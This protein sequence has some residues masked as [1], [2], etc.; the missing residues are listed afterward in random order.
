MTTYPAIRQTIHDTALALLALLAHTTTGN[1][2]RRVVL[3]LVLFVFGTFTT[4]TR[5]LLFLRPSVSIVCNTLYCRC[6]IGAYAIVGGWW[7][8]HQ[9]FGSR[10]NID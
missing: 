9:W 6:I 2:R 8:I 10:I 3:L 5:S 1:D 4:S 7:S